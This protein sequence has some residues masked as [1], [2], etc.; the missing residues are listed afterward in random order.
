VTF[1]DQQVERHQEGLIAIAYRAKATR[2]DQS[3][4]AI[5]TSTLLRKGEGDW[6]VIQHQQTPLGVEVADPDAK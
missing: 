6:E 1:H 4:H 2:G 3:Y 5:C